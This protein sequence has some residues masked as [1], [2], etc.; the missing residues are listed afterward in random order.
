VGF[1]GLFVKLTLQTNKKLDLKNLP[2]V[3]LYVVT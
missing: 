2:W 3:L 1:L